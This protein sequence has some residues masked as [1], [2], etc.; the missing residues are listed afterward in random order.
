M[1]GAIQQSLN[2]SNVD[3]TTVGTSPISTVGFSW[4]SYI[5]STM[6]KW[7][8]YALM[9]LGFPQSMNKRVFDSSGGP[10][11]QYKYV[12]DPSINYTFGG[13][14]KCSDMR[15]S[16]NRLFLNPLMYPHSLSGN[17]HNLEYTTKNTSCLDPK[18]ICMD[19]FPFS[20]V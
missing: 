6:E 18:W 9:A 4:I 8:Q 14:S 13:L 17:C 16:E 15:L 11:L 20:Y 7:F 1:W 19:M 5:R 10:V 2:T 3:Q 12:M